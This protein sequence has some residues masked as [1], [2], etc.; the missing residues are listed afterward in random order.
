MKDEAYRPNKIDAKIYLHPL[1]AF[2]KPHKRNPISYDKVN[3]V[4]IGSG[5]FNERV[6]KYCGENILNVQDIHFLAYVIVEYVST[7]S[8]T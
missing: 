4:K 8:S 7:F 5:T 2:L 6:K 3:Q 1:R